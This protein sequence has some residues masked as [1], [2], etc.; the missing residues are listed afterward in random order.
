MKNLFCKTRMLVMIAFISLNTQLNAQDKKYI[1]VTGSAETTILPDQ[2]MLQITIAGKD[3]KGLDKAE[4]D[5][6]KILKD[7]GIGEEAMQ[8][9]STNMYSW[10][11]WW[12]HYEEDAKSRTIKVRVTHSTGLRKLAKDLHVDWVKSV[13]MLSSSNSE[14]QRLRKEIKIQAMKAAKEKAAYLLESIGEQLGGVMYVL[15]M[16]EE[17]N[18]SYNNYASNSIV[19]A[20]YNSDNTIENSEE[21]KLRY[22]VKVTFEIK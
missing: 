20:P 1:E 12:G 10:G 11:Y 16:P 8:F 5:L 9:E 14:I 3:Q 13:Q 4:K 19:S 6:H 7:N 15:E 22:E 2:I 17:S 21:I 18:Y